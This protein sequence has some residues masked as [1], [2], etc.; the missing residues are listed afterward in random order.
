MGLRD[1]HQERSWATYQMREKLLAIG[2]DY[3]IEDNAGQRVFK[4]DGKALRFRDTFVLEDASGGELATIKE[5][6]LAIRDTMTIDFGGREAK[7]HKRMLG[8]RDRY[9]VD[10]DEGDDFTAKGDFVDHEYEI[11]RNG[12]KVAEISKK[13]FRIRET[14]GVAVK[15]GEDVALMLAIT[16]CIDA[17]AG[18]VG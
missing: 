5:K 9:V 1:R 6:K 17:M 13:W 16:V 12:D 18:V 4:V 3:W 2:D 8:I 14:Y 11:E 15:P 10:F 7:V